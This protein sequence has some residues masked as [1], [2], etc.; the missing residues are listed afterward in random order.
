MI[1]NQF[2]GDVLCM[3]MIFI[4]EREIRLTNLISSNI[5]SPVINLILQYWVCWGCAWQ[6]LIQIYDNFRGWCQPW[7]WAVPFL[8][9]FFLKGKRIIKLRSACICVIVLHRIEGT[10]GHE[11][12]VDAE[13]GRSRRSCFLPAYN[14]FKLSA[15]TNVSSWFQPLL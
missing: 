10:C 13:S 7:C 1:W 14:Q 3:T 15:L 12:H 4:Q 9:S 11:M 5:N 2:W 8:M 6:N